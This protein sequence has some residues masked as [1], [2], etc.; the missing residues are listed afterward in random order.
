MKLFFFSLL[1]SGM[2]MASNAQEAARQLGAENSYETA[3]DKA[4]KAHKIVVMVVVKEHCRWC[5][6]IIN[7][8]LSDAAVKEKLQKDFVTLIVDKDAPFPKAFRE[9]FFPSI[10]YIDPDT[11]KSIYENVGYIGAKCFINDLNSALETR[12]A[13]YGK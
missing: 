2:L 13:L 8:T 6:K 3:L 5:D 10:F 7:R 9:N 12:K 1:L 11:Q 4:Q